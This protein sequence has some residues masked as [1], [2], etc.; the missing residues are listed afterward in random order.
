MPHMAFYVGIEDGNPDPHAISRPMIPVFNKSKQTDKQM[1]EPGESTSKHPK[2]SFLFVLFSCKYW[3][4]IASLG[5]K[6]K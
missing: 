4:P 6:F 2:V 3:K 1:N 5:H